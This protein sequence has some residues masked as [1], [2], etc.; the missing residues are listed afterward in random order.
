MS[1]AALSMLNSRPLGA[2]D[3]SVSLDEWRVESAVGKE[4]LTFFTSLGGRKRCGRATALVRTS[5]ACQDVS[6][7]MVAR[8][9][10]LR[11]LL[12]YTASINVMKR[13]ARSL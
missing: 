1:L 4:C 5:F 7:R 10:L 12:S 9:A 11:T 6:G 3:G 8:L 13:L 2:G